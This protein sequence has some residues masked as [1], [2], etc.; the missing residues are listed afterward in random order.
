MK[1]ATRR[2]PIPDQARLLEQFGDGR[3]RPALRRGRRGRDI[4]PRSRLP[5]LAELLAIDARAEAAV[6]QARIAQDARGRGDGTSDTSSG[7]GPQE[8]R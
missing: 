6:A 4:D 7:C 2:P 8:K 1:R 3:R 5:T